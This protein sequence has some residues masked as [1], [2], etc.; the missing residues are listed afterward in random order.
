[1]NPAHKLVA[2]ISISEMLVNKN[3]IKSVDTRLQV[4]MNNSL[5]LMDE[6]NLLLPNKSIASGQFKNDCLP[7]TDIIYVFNVLLTI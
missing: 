7:Y 6:T 2:Q 1:M 3:I 5:V 4:N